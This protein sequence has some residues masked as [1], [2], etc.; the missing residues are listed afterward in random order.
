VIQEREQ[1]SDERRV[2]QAWRRVDD[3]EQ[4]AHG[5]AATGEAPRRR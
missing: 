5:Y 2:E 1:L 3:A 4:A